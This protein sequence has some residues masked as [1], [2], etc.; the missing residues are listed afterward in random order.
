MYEINTDGT[1]RYRYTPGTEGDE[2]GA[3]GTAFQNAVET[4][5]RIMGLCDSNEADIYL[6]SITETED[7]YKFTFDYRFN[8]GVIVVEDSRHSIKISA[9]ATRTMEAEMLPL[10]I[11]ALSGEEYIESEFVTQFL[12]VMNRNG[13]TELNK[14]EAYNMYLG[15]ENFS[16]KGDKYLKPVWIIEKKDGTKRILELPV[17][18]ARE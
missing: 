15:Y 4:M 3:L 9:T 11:Q 10:E 17:P 12:L 5:D 8:S 14:L 2:K 18:E 7:V 6:S 1:V 13:I 16:G